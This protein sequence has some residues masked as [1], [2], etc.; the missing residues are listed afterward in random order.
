MLHGQTT[1]SMLQGQPHIIIVFNMKFNGDI[2][3]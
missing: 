2:L 3:F 1:T